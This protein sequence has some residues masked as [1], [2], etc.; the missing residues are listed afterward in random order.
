MLIKLEDD[1]YVNPEHVSCINVFGNDLNKVFI[2]I[3]GQKLCSWTKN[4]PEEAK[5]FINKLNSKL[6]PER[7]EA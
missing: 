1:T 6:F 2:H 4:S 7:G 5:K 3:C